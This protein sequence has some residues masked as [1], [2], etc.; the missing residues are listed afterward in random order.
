MLAVN[1]ERR[2]WINTFVVEV[3]LT[4]I[5]DAGDYGKGEIKVTP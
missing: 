1:R 2:R 4:E 3:K 5:L